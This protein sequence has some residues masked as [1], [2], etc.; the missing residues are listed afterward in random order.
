[1]KATI[2]VVIGPLGLIN[3]DDDDDDNNNKIIIIIYSYGPFLQDSDS[4]AY[5]NK[6]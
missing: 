1:M 5:T 3:D 4:I 2:P 6:T